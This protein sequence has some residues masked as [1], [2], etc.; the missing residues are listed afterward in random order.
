MVKIILTVMSDRLPPLTALRAFEAAARHLSF[1]RAAAELAVTPA[2]LSFQIKALEDHLGHPLFRRL[3]RAVELTEAGRALAPGLS[4]GFGTL[5]RAWSAARR[6]TAPRGLSV[7]AGPAFTARWLAPRLFGFARLHPGI[8]LRFHAT[9]R[10]ADFARDEVDVAIRYAESVDPALY[11]EALLDDWVTPMMTPALAPRFPTPESLAAAPL[12][13]QDDAALARS[14]ADWPAWFRAAGVAGQP[15]AGT[16]FSQAD[17]AVDAA[18]S[19]AG[20][21]LGRHS[22]AHGALAAGQLVAPFPLALRTRARFWFVCAKG[23]E[24]RPQVR[25]F[26][27]WLLSEI[28]AMAPVAGPRTFASPDSAG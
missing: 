27:D 8:E 23:T 7:T 17:H 25:A 14:P 20:V 22:I 19:G 13:H 6:A 10:L 24:S 12:L 15:H 26:R 4:E 21:I 5:A 11:A 3:T 18:L 28:A 2:A 1:S 9:L 16:R